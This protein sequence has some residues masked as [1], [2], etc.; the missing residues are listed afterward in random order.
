MSWDNNQAI[1][2]GESLRAA[3]APGRFRSLLALTLAAAINLWLFSQGIALWDRFPERIPV[4][5]GPSGQADGWAPKS[6][7]SVFAPALLMTLLVVLIGVS[8]RISPKW[9]N[10]PGKERTMM[11]GPAYQEHV[12]APIREGTAWTVV[13]IMAVL[14]IIVRQGWSVAVGERDGVIGVALGLLLITLAVLPTI[15]GVLAARARLRALEEVS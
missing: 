5:F 3:G 8:L 1:P 9:C 13:G 6:V 4:P 11:L 14:A 15:A 12:V 10:F 2:D 7:F